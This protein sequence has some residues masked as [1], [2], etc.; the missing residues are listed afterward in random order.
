MIV[1]SAAQGDAS[2]LL[3]G[4]Q[5]ASYTRGWFSV[6][7]EALYQK[8]SPLQLHQGLEKGLA[9]AAAAAAPQQATANG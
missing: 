2:L 8:G 9:G 6:I 3:A 4:R 7:Q 5:P 1:I